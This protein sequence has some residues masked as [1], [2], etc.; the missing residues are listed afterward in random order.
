MSQGEAHAT[1]QFGTFA[2]VYG[3]DAATTSAPAPEAEA[4]AQQPEAAQSAATA[5]A[6][7]QQEDS[8]ECLSACALAS[9]LCGR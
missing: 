3:D 4:A 1:Q 8:G 7:P 2:S 5:A 6:Q 9:G